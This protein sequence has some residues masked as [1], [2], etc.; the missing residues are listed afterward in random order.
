MIKQEKCLICNNMGD[1]IF[2][3]KFSSD[4]I[5]KYFINYYGDKKKIKKILYKIKNSNYVVLKCNNCKF[6]WQK[7]RLNS[8]LQ[9]YLYDE[10]IDYKTSKNKSL[11]MYEMQKVSFKR[12]FDFLK[13]YFEDQNLNVLD[14]VR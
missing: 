11:K 12:D 10:L 4:K 2:N 6:M 14:Y 7:Y 3:L 1:E 13:N 9:K 8:N 5:K